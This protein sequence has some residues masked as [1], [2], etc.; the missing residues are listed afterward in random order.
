MQTR[1]RFRRQRRS[2]VRGRRNHSQYGAA[3]R[4]RLYSQEG[5]QVPK[6]EYLGPDGQEMIFFLT[7]YRTI[8]AEL[9]RFSFCMMCVRWVSTV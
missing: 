7:A 3:G 9:W 6:S 4:S 2:Q 1:P 8:S 5:M